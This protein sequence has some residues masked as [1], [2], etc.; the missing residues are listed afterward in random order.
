MQHPRFV[1]LAAVVVVVAALYLAQ[2]VLVPVALAV[3]LSFILSPLCSRLERLHL[4]RVPSVIAVTLLAFL[5]LGAV[6]WL[7]AGQASEMISRLPV[8]RENLQSRLS[9][10]HETI[11]RPLERATAAVQVLQ[12]NLTGQDAKGPSEPPAPVPRPEPM[13]KP[14]LDWFSIGLGSI[15]SRLG[16]AAIVVVLVFLMLLQRQDL[17]DR[18]IALGGSRMVVT[19]QA[20]DEGTRRLSRYL[21]VLTMI[22]GLQGVAVGLGLFAIGLPH[23]VLWGLMSAVLRFIPY[24]G[25][26]IAASFPALFA[27]A[28]STNWS[29]PLLVIGLFLVLECV[30]FYVVEP[31]VYPNHIGVS[32]T[33]LVVSAVFWTWLWGGPGLVL[34]TPLTVCLAVL[35]RYVPQLRFLSTILSDQPVLSP[36]SRL[37]QRVLALD[38]DEAWELVLAELKKGTSLVEVHDTILLPALCLAQQDHRERA[39]DDAA[40]GRVA[41]S[42]RELSEEAYDHHVSSRSS[43]PRADEAGAAAIPS[44]SPPLRV[45]C[46]PAGQEPDD[47]AGAM[48]RQVLRHAGVDAVELPHHTLASELL[49]S[50][51][52]KRA[53]AVCICQLPPL[54]FSRI[55]YSCKRIAARFPG[56][57]IL[58]ATWTVTLDPA[59]APERIHERA[60]LSFAAT[61]AEAQTQIEKIAADVRRSVATFE[62]ASEPAATARS[63]AT[64]AS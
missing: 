28:V 36:A 37:Y 19:T 3:F 17:R 60:K 15:F 57:P 43:I 13:V 38:P 23:A 5:I 34:A 30:S 27:L 8:Y 2:T 62:L 25:P 58:V 59:R 20:L 40:L 16:M 50:I 54:T 18:L 64:P 29:T 56:L 10:L 61:L 9:F 32:S 33:A 44:A 39:I 41:R 7:V 21:L 31:L 42:I 48:L 1:M 53:E 46:L 12:D 4:G 11:H 49:E 63:S 51:E 26:W 22:N 35:G 14:V 6:G 45:I 47:V 24:L 55:R 52:S